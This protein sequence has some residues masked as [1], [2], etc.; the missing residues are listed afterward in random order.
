[1]PNTAT[2]E[3]TVSY[4][5]TIKEKYPTEALAESDKLIKDCILE[6]LTAIK[7]YCQLVIIDYVYDH[8]K[9]I[10]NF[11]ITITSDMQAKE[12]EEKITENLSLF[13]NA[14]KNYKQD[15]SLITLISKK[16]LLNPHSIEKTQPLSQLFLMPGCMTKNTRD[17]KT[18]NLIRCVVK[19]G[20]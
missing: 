17:P 16:L 13:L 14:I 15:P 7:P 12:L 8:Q 19:C 1:M 9:F 6:F 20:H 3:C 2:I 11:N 5:E 10:T 4:R 18:Q